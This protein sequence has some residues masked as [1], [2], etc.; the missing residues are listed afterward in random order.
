MLA[1]CGNND[2]EELKPIDKPGDD[3]SE[4]IDDEEEGTVPEG[5][6]VVDFFDESR[7]PIEGSDNGRVTTLHYL[8]FSDAGAFVKQR[9]IEKP[10]GG[11]DWPLKNIK[12]TLP[13]GDYRVVF[14]ANSTA[15][16][17]TG[18][19]GGYT[20]TRLSLPDSGL[21]ASTEYYMG[22]GTF[23]DGAP[24]PGVILQR[25]IGAAQLHRNSIDAQAA[26][27]MLIANIFAQIN[28]GNIITTGLLGGVLKSDLLAAL[29]PLADN[30]I[31]NS[32]LYLVGGVE[33]IVDDIV[34]P[35]ANL[36]LQPLLDN[37]VHQIGGL[38]TGNSDQNTVLEGIGILLN[39]WAL[40]SANTA[41]VTINN[42]PRQ[43]DLDLNVT[44]RYAGEND[45]AIDFDNLEYFD[46]RNVFIRGF[47]EGTVGGTWD[48]RNINAVKSGLLPGLVVDA[49]ADDL[50]LKGS[51]VDITDPIAM[52][53]KPNIGYAN[54]YSLLD[55]GLKDYT[56]QTDGA[57]NLSLSVDLGNI[58]NL[59]QAL[60]AGIPILS[61]AAS[62]LLT[63]IINLLDITISLPVNVPLLGIEN[64]ALSGGWD[65][66]NTP[67]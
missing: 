48:I 27:D 13:N 12:D 35:I 30:F 7:A 66:T 2:D 1:S 26:L 36:I 16:T 47:G 56:Q 42:F 32:L 46:Q 45:F 23:S 40:S 19:E 37:L 55:L 52:P 57:H 34:Q 14:V 31:T 5:Y 64:L 21:T 38:L 43:I 10:D 4:Q 41:I 39:P 6:F 3:T 18:F 50:L 62:G 44:D 67:L 51:L 65:A 24:S 22:Q 25:I 59:D 9:E 60:L 63:P 29:G 17:L 54:N 8:I 49:I 20:A 33:G 28:Y 15:A 11:F 61:G 53:A 58:A